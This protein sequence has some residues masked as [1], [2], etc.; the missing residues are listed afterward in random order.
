MRQKNS[1]QDAESL[2]LSLLNMKMGLI[3]DVPTTSW[4]NW[5]LEGEKRC[6]NHSRR[7]KRLP[8]VVPSNQKV[9]SNQKDLSWILTGWRSD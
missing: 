6:K 1:E 2:K 8:K 3:I 5:R 9:S 4:D 7:W